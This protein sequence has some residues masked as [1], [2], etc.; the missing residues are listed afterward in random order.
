MNTDRNNIRQLGKRNP[1]DPA[2]AQRQ[3]EAARKTRLSAAAAQA[4]HNAGRNKRAKEAK[5]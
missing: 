3:A 4:R 5:Q 2:E 1:T